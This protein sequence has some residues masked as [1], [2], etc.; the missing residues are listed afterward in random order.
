[1]YWM[2]LRSRQTCQSQIA[3]SNS[4][5]SSVITPTSRNAGAGKDHPAAEE[6]AA[7]KPQADAAKNV[8]D[9]HSSGWTVTRAHRYADAGAARGCHPHLRPLRAAL[10]DAPVA[11]RIEHLTSDQKVGSSS[12]SGR[13]I[14]SAMVALLSENEFEL[15][16]NRRANSANSILLRQRRFT[17]VRA[18]RLLPGGQLPSRALAKAS[19]ADRAPRKG[20]DSDGMRTLFHL[21]AGEQT[22]CCT[23][24][25]RTG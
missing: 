22:R 5:S 10:P 13:A 9:E 20:R 14:A 3:S 18:G 6:Q 25:V 12:L 2:C 8:R 4:P 11:Q 23:A 16:S 24:G 21:N 7:G 19:A 15:C 1:M 17:S